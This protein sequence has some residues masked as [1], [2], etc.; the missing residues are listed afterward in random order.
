VSYA[1][2][3]GSGLGVLGIANATTNPS[4]NPSGGVVHYVDG[5]VHKILDSTGMV[6]N[7]N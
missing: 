7:L 6:T 3:T 2:I 1:G 5:G 4:A